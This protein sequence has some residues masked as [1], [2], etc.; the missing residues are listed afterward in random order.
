[1]GI[2][3]DSVLEYD[4]RKEF[5]DWI[6]TLHQS[7]VKALGISAIGLKKVKEKIRS[8]KGL[9]NR[10]KIFKA[11]ANLYKSKINWSIVK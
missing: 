9:K 11:M 3:N 8:G 4:N 7:E 5:H 2:D 10:L 6:L 1:M